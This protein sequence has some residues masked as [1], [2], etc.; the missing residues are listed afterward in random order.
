MNGELIAKLESASEGSREKFWS[1]VDIRG[2]EECWPWTGYRNERG[3]G[4]FSYAKA[5]AAKAHRIAYTIAK[6]RIPD[7]ALICHSCDN[8]SCCNPAH[9]WPGSNRDNNADRHAKGRS[10][11]FGHGAPVPRPVGEQHSSAKLTEASV[12]DIRS[13]DLPASHFAE[14]YG[15][16]VST[17]CRVRR[18]ETWTAAIIRAS[19]AQG[20]GE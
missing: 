1:R 12:A 5:S 20:A 18:G 17:V 14:K 2:A 10:V 16:T 19:A 9:L 8:P 13:S 6:G 11:C 15:V 7:G 4:V 3:Y